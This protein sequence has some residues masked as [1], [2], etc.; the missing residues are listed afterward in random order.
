LSHR[1][2]DTAKHKFANSKLSSKR[3]C[4]R[5]LGL[6][7]KKTRGRK[8]CIRVALKGQCH[9]IFDPRFFSSNN[10]TMDPDSRADAVLHKASYSPRYD[11]IRGLINTVGSDSTVSVIQWNPNFS[12]DYFDFLGEM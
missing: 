9:E 4:L 1:Y 6:F 12:N 7:D 3:L 8:S 5:G 10:L 2:F 11:L